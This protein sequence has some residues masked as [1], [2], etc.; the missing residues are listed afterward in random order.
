MKFILLR[1]SA[2]FNLETSVLP[3]FAD[4]LPH[5]SGSAHR[6][7]QNLVQHQNKVLVALGR[8]ETGL[9]QDTIGSCFDEKYLLKSFNW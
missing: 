1:D 6:Q 2:F 7:P 4:F 8:S 3:D 5:V 9:F